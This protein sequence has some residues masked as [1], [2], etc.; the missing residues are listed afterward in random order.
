MWSICC[1][2]SSEAE[3]HEKRLKL[4]S[5]LP[6]NL[7]FSTQIALTTMTL[8]L[9]LLLLLLLLTSKLLLLLL[10]EILANYLHFFL[11]VL[12]V[13]LWPVYGYAIF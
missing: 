13:K 12:H 8:L 1:I 4:K 5:L 11:C 6:E 2:P 10:L 9:I 7:E 3:F